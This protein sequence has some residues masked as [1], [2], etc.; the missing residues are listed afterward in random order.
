[1]GDSAF[2]VVPSPNWYRTFQPQQRAVESLRRAHTCMKFPEICVTPVRFVI[3]A[4]AERPVVVPSPNCP[5]P[6]SPQQAT[7]PSD[8]KAHA[9]PCPAMICV[10]SVNPVTCTG[11]V[12]VVVVPSPNCLTLL[13]PQH[14]TV[15]S[16]LIAQVNESPVATREKPVIGAAF[17][18]C[19]DCIA[20]GSATTI[21]P[22]MRAAR[23]QRRKVLIREAGNNVILCIV[24]IICA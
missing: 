2:V 16:V 5:D 15:P 7:V 9:N 19:G 22:T 4:G 13:R 12:L 14:Q 11:R 20:T 6:L 10:A 23:L 17:A 18:R 1:M 24:C 21:S 3:T 8:F